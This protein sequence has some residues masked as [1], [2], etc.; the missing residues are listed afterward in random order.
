MTGDEGPKGGSCSGS[1][2]LSDDELLSFVEEVQNG[3][4]TARRDLSCFINTSFLNSNGILEQQ[5]P[6]F[7]T[8][9]RSHLEIS[10]VLRRRHTV[11]MR[12][13]EPLSKS[14]FCFTGFIF[15]LVVVA[16]QLAL[17]PVAQSTTSGATTSLKFLKGHSNVCS[18]L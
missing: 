17:S 12:K 5:R 14:L 7:H 15:L 8:K 13:R 6:K 3:Y 16:G 9:Q 1:P 2:K 18:Q 10:N 4:S 11:Q